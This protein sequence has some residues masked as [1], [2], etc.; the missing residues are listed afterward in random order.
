MKVSEKNE[1]CGNIKALRNP[2][3]YHV[4]TGGIFYRDRTKALQQ[5][6][7]HGREI[8]FALPFVFDIKIKFPPRRGGNMS[9]GIRLAGEHRPRRPG[10]DAHCGA[11]NI[12][13]FRSELRMTCHG[14]GT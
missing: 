5:K 10:E 3:V 2:L 4:Q 13:A 11:Y 1:T 8:R 6:I 7:L 14:K 12:V 9:R